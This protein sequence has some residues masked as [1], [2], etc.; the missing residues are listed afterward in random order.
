MKKLVFVT[1]IV[2]LFFLFASTVKI[3]GRPQAMFE[4][5]LEHYFIAYGLT[6]QIMFLVGLAE[7]CGAVTIWYH[8]THW[9]GLMG[10]ALLVVVTTGAIVFHLR[11]DTVREAIPAIVMLVLSGYVLLF[12]GRDQLNARGR[13]AASETT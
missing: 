10:A 12:S 2:S 1:G 6:R 3:F 13:S 11:F 9:I 5:Q 7:L 4:Y 8:R